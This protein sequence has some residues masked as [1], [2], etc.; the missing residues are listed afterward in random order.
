MTSK[1]NIHPTSLPGVKL[2]ERYLAEDHRGFYAEIYNEQMYFDKGITVKFVEQDF[3]FSQRNV[4]RGLHG[5]AKTWKLISC[6]FGEF[7]LVVLNYDTNSPYFG[8]WES[9]VLTP[10]NRLQVL[11][12]PMYANGHL[13]LSDWAMFHYNQSEYY[14]D[15]K[16]QFVVKWNDHRFNIDWPV[17]NPI[18]SKR[19]S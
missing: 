17:K 14:T 7:L 9:F 15:G 12:P 8:E 4:L 5:D 1:I 6:L 16:N 13:V 18:L 11:I 10:A 3:S 19:D 2:I